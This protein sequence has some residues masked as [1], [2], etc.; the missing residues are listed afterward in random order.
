M[1]HIDYKH[2]TPMDK[3]LPGWTPWTKEKWNAWLKK[4]GDL[5][6]EAARLDA[7]RVAL[8]KAGDAKNAEAKRLARNEFISKNSAHWG[9]LKDWLMALSDGKCWFT[10]TTNNGSYYDVEHFRP[11]AEAKAI[12]GTARDGY[13]WL[14]FDYTNY[15]LAGSVPNTKKGGWFPLCDGTLVSTS[16]VRCEASEMPYLLDPISPTDH[17]LLAF[18]EEGNATPTPSPDEWS[19][20]QGQWEKDRAKESITRYKLNE[21]DILPAKRR[22]LL[23][24]LTG[25]INDYL[26][27]KTSFHP[28][29]NPVPKAT[30]EA[31]AENIERITQP[32]V[33]FSSVARY[34]I[35]LR[36]DPQLSRLVK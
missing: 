6:T 33:E 29:R 8:E 30:M 1:R 4:S 31:A 17:A 12:D 27:A 11:K 18:D 9:K 5:H 32:T 28:M 14:A 25:F 34:Y 2:K 22:E 21:H 7:E 16:A 24:E 15:R 10:D 23:K 20:P 19:T 35:L 26:N 3:H 13:W 36:N